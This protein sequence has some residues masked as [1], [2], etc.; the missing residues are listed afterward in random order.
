MS[1]RQR[2]LAVGAD[3]FVSIDHEAAVRAGARLDV[4]KW[5]AAGDAARFTDRVG[6]TAVGANRP[7]Q[8]VG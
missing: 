5:S 3:R 1:Y 6:G 7:A 8:A 2:P 4:T